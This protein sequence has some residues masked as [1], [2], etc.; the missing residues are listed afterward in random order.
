MPQAVCA[1]KFAIAG[2]NEARNELVRSEAGDEWYGPC[3]AA[4]EMLEMI[5]AALEFPRGR[6]NLGDLDRLFFNVN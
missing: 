5:L 6:V 2:I 4:G 3:V 1:L